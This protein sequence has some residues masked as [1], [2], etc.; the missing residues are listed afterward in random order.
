MCLAV[1]A[2]RVPLRLLRAVWHSINVAL[3][4]CSWEWFLVCWSGYGGGVGR[5]GGTV[6]RTQARQTQ[7]GEVAANAFGLHFRT[8]F[9]DLYT[10][11]SS[12]WVCP[13]TEVARELWELKG[14]LTREEV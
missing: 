11:T 10:A 4:F 1:D 8:L 5:S 9:W 14:G 7:H 13:H 3:G 12:G 2:K 6:H